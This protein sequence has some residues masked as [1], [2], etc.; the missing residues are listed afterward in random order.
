[1]SL[2]Y[3]VKFKK[4]KGFPYSL[5]S[6]GPGADPGV[7][8]VSQQVTQ[9]IHYFPP[10]LRLPSQLQSITAFGWYS[11]YRPTE[12]RRL[13]RP[14]WVAGYIPKIKCRLRESNP[15][16]VTHPSTNRAQRR[17]TLLIETNA[18]PLRKTATSCEIVMSKKQQQPESCTVITMCHKV[19]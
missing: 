5:P 18:L 2:H 8:A 12:S 9:V 14:G 16:M 7:Q 17:L 15:D 3:L 11:F 13:N 6:V 4:G 19:V 1:M 10:G